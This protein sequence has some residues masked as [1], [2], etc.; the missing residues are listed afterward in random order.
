MKDVPVGSSLHIQTQNTL[1]RLR[2]DTEGDWSIMGH[3]KYCPVWTKV[4]VAGSTWGGSMLKMKFI[5]RGMHME[6]YI[7]GFSPI[8]TTAIASIEE[9]RP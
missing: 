9:V 5:G 6:F 4:T 2:R 1:Y 7:A 3:L 8:T